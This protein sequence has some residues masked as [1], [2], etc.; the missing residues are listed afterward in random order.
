MIGMPEWSVYVD[1][2]ILGSWILYHQKRDKV[3]EAGPRIVES[4]KLL[5]EMEKGHLDHQFESSTWAIAEL[6]GIIV[7]NA[8]AEQMMKDG[9][10]LF[11][12]PSQKRVFKV[13]DESTKRGIVENL[14]AFT[15]HLLD[16]GFIIRSYE[17]DDDS[18]ID[19]LFRH[20]FLPTPDALHLSFAI[21]S[22]DVFL[23]LDQRHFLEKR[24]EIQKDN[25]IKILRPFEL[26]EI[27]KQSKHH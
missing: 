6:A 17:I 2:S 9:I 18:V 14:A 1:T 11:E 22:C 16:I 7:D 19:L 8:L 15:E 4:Y 27:T 13:E 12:F 26:L 5:S 3:V 25:K 23:T 20:T 24:K 10:S 21:D